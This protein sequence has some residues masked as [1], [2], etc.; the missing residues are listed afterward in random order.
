M[1]VYQGDS[2]Y[3]FSTLFPTLSFR[4]YRHEWNKVYP[5]D[6]ALLKIEISQL[7]INS[8]KLI[9]EKKL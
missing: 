2:Y 3:F 8:L 6:M 4:R 1:Y 7:T 9:N 5:K